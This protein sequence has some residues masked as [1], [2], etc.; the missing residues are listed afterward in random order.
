MIQTFLQYHPC[1]THKLSIQF[2]VPRT[3]TNYL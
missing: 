3:F 1:A 2:K